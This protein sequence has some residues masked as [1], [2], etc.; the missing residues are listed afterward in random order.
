MNDISTIGLMWRELRDVRAVVSRM[1]HFEPSM[2]HRPGGLVARLA[3][4]A[5]IAS[6]ERR[7]PTDVALQISA[8]DC[9]LMGVRELKAA[10]GP[11]MTTQSTWAIDLVNTVVQDLADN[12]LPESARLKKPFGG[13]RCKSFLKSF[14]E[15]VAN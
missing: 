4:V 14:G 12:L 1:D 3:T 7:E 10:I 11:A 6:T 8:K 13:G 2:T 5:L 15:A 9:A